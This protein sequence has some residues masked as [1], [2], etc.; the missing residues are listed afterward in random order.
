MPNH[1]C[2]HWNTLFC[3][4]KARASFNACV[5]DNGAPDIYS[6]ADGYADSVMLLIE[7]LKNNRGTLDTLIYPICFN[8]RH[9]VELT[10][11]GQINDLAHL[12]RVRKQPLEK[13][14][15]F[16]KI[17]NQ[18]DIQNL[19][20]F[21]VQNAHDIDRRYSESITSLTPYIK[22]ITE[23]DP[24]GQTFRYSYNTESIKHLTNTSIINVLVLQEQFMLIRNELERLQSITAMMISEY[25]TGTFTPHLS[26][27]DLVIIANQL[28]AR[29]V[30]GD[31]NFKNIKERLKIEYDIGSKELSQALKLIQETRDMGKVI[32]ICFAI[33]GLSIE[34]LVHL[35]DIWK[36]AWDIRVLENKL[37][38][39]IN[40]PESQP[41]KAENMM[42]LLLR[43]RKAKKNTDYAKDLFV[44]WIT[45]TR[46]AGLFTLLD[47]NYAFSE[48]YDSQYSKY[49]ND[50]KGMS[51]NLINFEIRDCWLRRVGTANFPALIVNKLKSSGF[52]EESSFMA[53]TLFS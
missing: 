14:P 49:L 26:R 38:S 24:T 9:S 2:F 43:E 16:G 41:P 25:S 32:G 52:A 44:Q 7:D 23:I 30:W 29:D 1:E 53:E 36:S 42:N 17:L 18:H 31:K 6:Y 22:C 48:D 8:L 21:F 19:W 39:Y 12:A 46:L 51:L 11:K 10:I 3:G 50:F 27:N 45:P 37:R 28:P 34:E 13:A 35:S 4:D 40:T 20:D 5:G 33:P 47:S 15:Q